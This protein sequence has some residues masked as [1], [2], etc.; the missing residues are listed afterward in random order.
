M[1]RGFGRTHS[2]SLTAVLVR[3]GGLLATL[4]G[5][6]LSSILSDCLACL[7][8]R[9]WQRRG[10]LQSCGGGEAARRCLFCTV[11][12]YDFL[13]CPLRPWLAKCSVSFRCCGPLCL[14]NELQ[15]GHVRGEISL[16]EF[17][18]SLYLT[19]FC[20]PQRRCRQFHR[21]LLVPSWRRMTRRAAFCRFRAPAN[22]AP[23]TAVLPA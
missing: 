14:V 6:P 4:S 8:F 12:P 1:C 2:L 16:E 3:F 20:V 9:Q 13:L 18:Y 23:A 10:G 5:R 22:G 21:A 19:A 17:R 15:A 11:I 7:L